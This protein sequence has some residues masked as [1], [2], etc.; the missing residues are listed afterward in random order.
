MREL[1]VST[2]NGKWCGGKFGLNE[3]KFET[4]KEAAAAWKALPN[5]DVIPCSQCIGEAFK[6]NGIK[7]KLLA[8]IH[9]L[10][11]DA[12]LVIDEQRLDMGS[13]EIY[14]RVKHDGSWG[15]FDI[16]ELEKES[17]LL[18]LQSRGGNN[19]WAEDTVGILLGHGH[20]HPR[21]GEEQ[22][23]AN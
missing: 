8:E 7:P 23:N 4:I 2:G 15:T 17:L 9:L 20:L 6:Q 14:I 18:W 21:L 12:A 16:Y 11:E 10:P 1:H 5:T 3:E 22:N 19:P 13:T